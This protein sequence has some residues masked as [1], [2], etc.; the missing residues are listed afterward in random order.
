MASSDQPGPVPAAA[1]AGG[2][3]AWSRVLLKL[4]GE[5]LM[6]DQGYGIDPEQIA[7]VA[8]VVKGATDRDV[9]VAVVVGAGNIF[10]GVIG[11]A[12]GMD[13]ATADYMGMMATMRNA[14]AIRDAL[15]KLGVTTRIQS[16]VAMQ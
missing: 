6:G 16:G 13:R 14:L 10:R 5:A 8:R 4:S 11:A 9:E 7:G 3:A 2:H 15:E 12:S 1:G